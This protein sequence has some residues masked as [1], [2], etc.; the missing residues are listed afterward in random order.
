MQ[1]AGFLVDEK[2]HRHTPLALARQ[3]PVG[4]VGDHAM[5][6]RL[7]PAREERGIFNR[8]QGGSAQAWMAVLRQVVHAGEPLRSGAVDD[9]RFMAPAMHVAVIEHHQLE[10]RTDFFQLAA[11]RLGSFP[12]SHAGKERQ[13]G[14]ELAIAHDRADDV[15]V[16][17]AM[18]F[19]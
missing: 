13:P 2:R 3:C 17:H 15:V 19:A 9:R 5:Q 7:A 10:Q 8:L 4:T 6:A 14:R 12:D 16:F 1:L 18:R 11:D